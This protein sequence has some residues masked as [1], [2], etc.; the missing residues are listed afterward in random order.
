MEMADILFKKGSTVITAP[1]DTTVL[2]AA[3]IMTENKIGLLL[4]CNQPNRLLGWISER[5]IVGIV[6]ESTTD[7][8]QL[9]VESLIHREYTICSS[10]DDPRDVLNT[11]HD[12]GYRY[13][14]V[15][16]Y[17]MLKG[18]VSSRDILLFLVEES[19]AGENSIAWAAS[20]FL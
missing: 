3:R 14:P 19:D 17:G 4:I 12:L 16:E 18:L 13:V 5:D 8:S 1:P 20:D 6:A 11:L 9:T 7:L 10:H 15:I 2:A